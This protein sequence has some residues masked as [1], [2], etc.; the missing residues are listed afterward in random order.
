MQQL[1]GH[2]GGQVLSDEDA[3]TAALF[4]GLD[5]LCV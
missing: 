5:E 2:V 3:N 4:C 1:L